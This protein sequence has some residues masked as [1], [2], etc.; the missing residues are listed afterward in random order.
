MGAVTDEITAEVDQLR[1]RD[2]APGL[3]ALAVSLAQ[4]VDAATAPTGK[5]LAAKELRSVIGE[6]RKLAPV[7]EEG[8][9]LDELTARREAR[10]AAGE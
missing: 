10:R 3:A 5:A 8:D 7:G 6:L 2:T 9:A 1:G 4:T